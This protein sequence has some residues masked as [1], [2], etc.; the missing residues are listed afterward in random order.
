MDAWAARNAAYTNVDPES[1]FSIDFAGMRFSAADMDGMRDRT[2]AAMREMA[3]IEAGEIK[4]PDENRKVTHFTDR[5][6]YPESELFAQV[7]RFAA[8]VRSGAVRGG[9]GETFDAV[10]VNGIGGSAL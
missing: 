2:A 6:T 7:E 3:R 10:V 1:G 8:D 9:K 4:N 5:I